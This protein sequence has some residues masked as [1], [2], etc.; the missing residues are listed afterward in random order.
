MKQFFIIIFSCFIFHI[1]ADAQYN[2]EWIDFAKTYYKF[3]VGAT[4]L[5]R[6]NAAQ[7]PAALSNVDA[8]QFQLWRNGQ[9]VAIYTSV[10]S[11]TL[12]ATGYIEFE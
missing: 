4:G 2:N 5:Y 3:K 7:L 8:S 1:A 12:P 11:G 6:I 10:A 9:Q